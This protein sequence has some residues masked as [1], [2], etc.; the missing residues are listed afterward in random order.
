MKHELKKKGERR[1]RDHFDPDLTH[2]LVDRSFI[3][4]THIPG[5]SGRCF[6]IGSV[7][8]CHYFQIKI[9]EPKSSLAIELEL[10][11]S[12]RSEEH[13]SELQSQ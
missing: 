7:W 1:L 13:T 4:D 9:V 5:L 8:R 11:I 3:M 2:I 6:I 12:T 10:E